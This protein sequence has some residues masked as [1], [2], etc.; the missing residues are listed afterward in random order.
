[1]ITTVSQ[2][3]V[4]GD[5][6]IYGFQN[7]SDFSLHPKSQFLRIL[8]IGTPAAIPPSIFSVATLA[9]M[10]CTNI[11]CYHR[12]DRSGFRDELNIPDFREISIHTERMM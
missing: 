1:M 5:Y 12:L 9:H 8:Q 2:D 11:Y 10:Y 4:Q 3:V 6:V 7:A